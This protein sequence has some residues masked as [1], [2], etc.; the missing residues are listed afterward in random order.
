MQSGFVMSTTSTFLS[1]ERITKT[2]ST[3]AYRHE[4]F[5]T[6]RKWAGF[7]R[8][9]HDETRGGGREKRRKNQFFFFIKKM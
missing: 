1:D 8:N 4:I 2:Y 7:R 3:R 5:Y 6:T 9:V